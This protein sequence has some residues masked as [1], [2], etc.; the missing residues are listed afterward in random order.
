MRKL[1]AMFIL[2]ILLT[3]AVAG[4]SQS[5]K[6]SNQKA[7]NKLNIVTTI[8]PEYDFT[9][10]IVKDKANLTM[11]ITPGASIH[12]YDP[13]PA[14]LIKIK[15]ADVFIYIG[16]ESDTWVDRILESMDTSKMTVIRLIDYVKAVEEE[17]IEGMESEEE[18]EV[19]DGEWQE[20][21]ATPEY[22]EHI[23]TSPKNAMLLVD[24]ISDCLCLRDSANANFYKKNSDDYINEIKKVDEEITT[25]VKDAKRNNIVVADKFPFRYFVDEYGLDYCAAF[26]GCSDQTDA[27]AATIAYL[28]DT[29]TTGSMPYI[30]YVELSNQNVAKAVSEQTGA[31]MLLLNSCHNVSKP[32]F[33]SGVTYVSLMK[34]NAENLKLALN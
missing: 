29:V 17:T 19:S 12:S 15:N 33:D 11:L 1:I 31:K 4:C 27:S 28:V 20:I 3:T 10:A 30:F 8:Y 9:R 14:D 7:D 16:G 5:N 34:Q 22:D 32:D 6:A 25:V 24:A 2:G 13:S 21:A 18:E 26:G 23:W